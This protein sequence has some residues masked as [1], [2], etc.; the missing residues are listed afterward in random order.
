MNVPHY[1]L[2]KSARSMLLLALLLLL[3]MTG[4]A[5]VARPMTLIDETR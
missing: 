5:F 1:N 2:V 4:V 3:F